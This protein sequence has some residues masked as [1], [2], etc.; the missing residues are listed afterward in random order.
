[1]EHLRAKIKK[2]ILRGAKKYGKLIGIKGMDSWTVQKTI[3]WIIAKSFWSVKFIRCD[4]SGRNS[5]HFSGPSCM[6]DAFYVG[7]PM[8]APWGL[9]HKEQKTYF[10][11]QKS[12]FC[13]ASHS[14]T[15]FSAKTQPFEL[16]LNF[17]DRAEYRL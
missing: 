17:L 16:S 15:S 8:Y 13:G 6:I 2:K 12:Y 14:E 7:S 1:M 9:F 5:S 11:E 3:K 10:Y 4:A